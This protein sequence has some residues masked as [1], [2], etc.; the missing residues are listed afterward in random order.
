M[1][2]F[3]Q[4]RTDTIFVMLGS[5]CNLHCRYCLQKCQS[6]PQLP[7]DINPEIY[8][9][10]SECC[11][12]ND[13]SPVQLHFY[14]GEPLLY[15]G[16]IKEIV[17]N[18]NGMNVRYS[19]ITNGKAI[20]RPVA[21][22]L[23]E[24]RFSVAVSWDGPNVKETRGYD[25]LEN[26]HDNIMMLNDLGLSAVLSAKCYPE[27]IL[28]AF[29]KVS[30]EYAP[31]HKGRSIGVNLDFIFDTGIADKTLIQKID[32]GRMHE[33]SYRLTKDF[34]SAIKTG[35]ADSPEYAWQLQCYS[36]IRACYKDT[37]K[38]RLP[39]FAPC[40]NGYET[41]NMDLAG[42]LYT[43]HNVF[44]P[45]GSIHTPYISY[46]ASIVKDDTTVNGKEMCGNCVA[47]PMCHGGCKLVSLEDKP[48]KYCK[49]RKAVFGGVTQAYIEEST[50][51]KEG[52][53]DGKSF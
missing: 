27:E 39:V 36:T 53:E 35:N 47:K 32:Y 1:Q 12:M 43:C 2:K 14:G 28:G 22:W 31:L 4:R 17:K 44:H 45:V 46:I 41:L 24:H 40:G 6:I 33:E 16:S 34:F 5:G 51:P 10:I 42:N 3:L 7:H 30:K 21:E 38:Y 15:F 49:I 52:K 37:E 48:E 11:E 8:D 13:G 23:N 50:N 18:T 20:T 25:V 26:N 9:F 29:S 19:I